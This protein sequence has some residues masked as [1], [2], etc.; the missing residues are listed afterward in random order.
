MS[1][2]ALPNLLSVQIAMAST[3]E[4]H[5]E[6]SCIRDV[7]SNKGKSGGGSEWRPEYSDVYGL[8][9]LEEEGNDIKGR[10]KI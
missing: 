9:C 4:I 8:T 1:L 10:P 3:S 5:E 2:S 6:R 7:S